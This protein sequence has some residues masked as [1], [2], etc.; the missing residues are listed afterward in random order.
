MSAASVA[1]PAAI[2]VLYVGAFVLSLRHPV[3]GGGFGSLDA[4]TLLFQNRWALLAG[5]I[6]YLAF[7]LFVGTWIVRDAAD[8]HIFHPI[9]VP[10]LVL[11]FMLG[12]AGLL[13]YLLLRG[14]LT[15]P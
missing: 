4:V 6:H 8:R 3:A 7:D 12:P 5:W 2:G 10:F 15:R 11:T 14:R 1:I 9:L 13:G